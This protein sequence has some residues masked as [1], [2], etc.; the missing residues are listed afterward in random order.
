VLNPAGLPATGAARIADRVWAGWNWP[1]AQGGLHSLENDRLSPLQKVEKI[2]GGAFRAEKPD[3]KRQSKAAW[4]EGYCDAIVQSAANYPCE[5]APVDV[6]LASGE[7]VHFNREE[8]KGILAYFTRKSGIRG[9]IFFGDRQ[10][11]V[12]AEAFHLLSATSSAVSRRSLR[13]QW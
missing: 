9:Q 8:L 6:R 1:T 7:V 2:S 5:P 11:R 13:C 4:W 3:P 12:S 10:T